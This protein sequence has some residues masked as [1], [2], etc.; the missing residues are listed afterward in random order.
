MSAVLSMPPGYYDALKRLT[1]EVSG[2]RIGD[3]YQ[4]IIETRLAYIARTEG[5]ALSLIHISEPTRPY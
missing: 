4:F 5:Y 2:V 1:A 3:N